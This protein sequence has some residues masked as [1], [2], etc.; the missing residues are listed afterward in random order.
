MVLSVPPLLEGMGQEVR[1]NVQQALAAWQGE[2]W[3]A[4]QRLREDAESPP[5]ARWMGTVAQLSSVIGG[6]VLV[7]GEGEAPVVVPLPSAAVPTV[8]EHSDDPLV[9]LEGAP[10]QSGRYAALSI[11]I[12]TSIGIWPAAVS[13]GDNGAKDAQALRG[14]DDRPLALQVIA[15]ST[16]R[17]SRSAWLR[18]CFGGAHQSSSPR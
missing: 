7:G 3:D 15:R 12:G 16:S 5:D 18:T 13:V 6:S 11:V 4:A 9:R 1:T 17:A 2:L 8:K 14:A 10:G